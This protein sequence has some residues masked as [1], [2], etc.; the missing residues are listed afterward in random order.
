MPS[1][2]C[3]QGPSWSGSF[4]DSSPVSS[5]ARSREHPGWALSFCSLHPGGSGKPGFLLA[6]SLWPPPT[7]ASWAP[8]P[9]EPCACAS[10]G[11]ELTLSSSHPVFRTTHHCRVW[12]SGI[13]PVESSQDPPAAPQHPHPNTPDTLAHWTATLP[14]MENQG[15]AGSSLL[16]APACPAP[17]QSQHAWRTPQT[18]RVTREYW[19]SLWG[20]RT[21]VQGKEGEGE[22]AGRIGRSRT[23]GFFQCRTEGP[24]P[25]PALGRRGQWGWDVEGRRQEQASQ[26][27]SVGTDCSSHWEHV[28]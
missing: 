20:A 24:G 18:C 10:L 26:G 11:L 6:S 13:R 22:E 4:P 8:G 28:W 14:T 2:D 17:P 23:R 15:T 9:D 19:S 5:H 7:P 27:G 21:G 25:A 1:E 16:A 12:A 3:E